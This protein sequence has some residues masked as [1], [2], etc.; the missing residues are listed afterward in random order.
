MKPYA[1]TFAFVL[2][3]YACSDNVVTKS[4]SVEAFDGEVP[5]TAYSLTRAE[6]IKAEQAAARGDI[7]ADKDLAFHFGL[8]GEEAKSEAHFSRCLTALHPECLAEKAN[9]FIRDA[10]DPQISQSDRV[11]L[12]KEALRFNGQAIVADRRQGNSRKD[13]YLAQ[14]RAITDLLHGKS[15]DELGP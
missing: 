12:L 8:A 7:E 9:H 10:I 1:C 11:K 13:D 2:L 15:I 6:V 14:R 5:G 3:L 4:E